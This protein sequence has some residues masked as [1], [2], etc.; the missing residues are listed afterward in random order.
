MKARVLRLIAHENHFQTLCSLGLPV[1]GYAIVDEHGQIVWTDDEAPAHGERLLQARDVVGSKIPENGSYQFAAALFG[2]QGQVFSMHMADETDGYIAQM[3]LLIGPTIE[4]QGKG[5]DRVHLAMMA[6]ATTLQQEFVL[7]KELEVMATELGERYEELNL[8]FQSDLSGQRLAYGFES[9]RR[10]VKD[11]TAYLNVGLAAL[12]LPT[13]SFEVY[14]LDDQI[15]VPDAPRLLDQMRGEFFELM[16]DTGEPF[17]INNV[18]DLGR[19][20]IDADLS[21]KVMSVPIQFGPDDVQ[22]MLVAANAPDRPDFENSDRNLLD[23]MANKVVKVLQANFDMMTG[24]ENARSFEWAVG[25][26]LGRSHSR[27]LKHALLHVDIDRTNVVNDISGRDAGDAVIRRVA[28]I[29]G[30]AVRAQDTVARLGSDEF[31]VLLETCSLDAAARLATKI[32]RRVE[33]ENFNWKGTI[34]P[35]SVCIGVAPVT[36]ASE[37]VAAVLSA[38]EVARQAAQERGRNRVQVYELND[39]D[40]LRRRGEFRWVGRIQAALREDRFTLFAQPIVPVF[41]GRGVPHYEVLLRMRGEKGELITP[42]RFIPAAEHYHLMAEID[43][44]VVRAAVDALLSLSNDRQPLPEIYSVNLSGQSLADESVLDTVHHELERLG[45]LVENL[46][47]EITESAVIANMD[48]ALAFIAFA[49]GYGVKFALDDFG[50]GLSSFAYLKRFD[51]DYLKIDGSFV[52]QVHEDPVSEAMVAAINRVGQVMGLATI[53]E[54]V[55]NDAIVRKLK[56]IGVNY[57]QGYHFGKPLPLA[58]VIRAAHP[59]SDAASG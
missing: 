24:L 54:F 35:L 3:V 47:F 28:E 36:A 48:E 4:L 40:L 30:N 12:L 56:Q 31:G 14:D 32:C 37:S 53:A 49:K 19:T 2:D 27:G 44:W 52:R 51:V 57:A 58:E 5:L 9:L 50:S 25:Q 34:H 22:G 16:R 10:L 13:K 8:V 42:N 20:R 46:V 45:P 1:E 39:A 33:S 7:N 21:S 17:V 23:V 6:A 41:T 18:R 55:E 29:L 43:R 26:S 11:T 15:S 59:P 38:A